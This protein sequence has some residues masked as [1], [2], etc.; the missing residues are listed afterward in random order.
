MDFTLSEEQ[1][2]LRRLARDFLSANC[3]SSLVR[4]IAKR[5]ADLNPELWRNMAQM[6]W[7][8]IIVPEQYGGMGGSF[9]DMVILLEE[10]GYACL[11]SPFFSGLIGSIALYEM[12]NDK[13]KQELL[14][15]IV[16]GELMITLAFTEPKARYD[17]QGIATKAVLE[18]NKY[19]I[20]GTKLFVSDA[21]RADYLVCPARSGKGITVFL[22]ET[23]SPGIS[24]TP[25]NTIAG[26]R[27]YE[28]LLDKVSASKENI[29]G[30]A[31]KGWNALQS[32]MRKATV[33]KC[34]EMVG[35]AQKA[36]DMTLDYAKER[37]QF[38]RPIGSFQ[39]IQHYCANMAIDVDA[40]RF[41][42]RETAWNLNN[43]QANVKGVA[44]AKTFVSDAFIRV[45][46][47]AH[48]IHGAIGTTE[49][50]EL[51]LYSKN[52]IASRALFGDPSFHR[53]IVAQEIGL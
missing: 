24:C 43:G 48:Q 1:E 30:K 40:A 21:H 39:A 36:L 6:G 14:P 15:R 34:A 17:D 25:L 2:M 26:D 45:T 31:G 27:Q 8:G 23:R 12:G 49:D 5:E 3:P 52:A 18:G 42:N 38:G 20:N 7:M 19:T 9:L 16:Q 46:T 41:I 4:K 11:P 53:E 47:I 32:V 13:Q 35:G 29:L 44:V 22:L 37:K 50:H 10:T 28:V 33:A 51:P